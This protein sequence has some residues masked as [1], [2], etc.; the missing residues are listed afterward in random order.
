MGTV[1]R[2][3]GKQKPAAAPTTALAVAVLAALLAVIL[4][5][6]GCGPGPG[7]S[8]ALPPRGEVTLSGWTSSPAE[9]KLVK[10][11]VAS[12]QTLNPQI[13]V[14]YRPIRDYYLETLRADLA[15]G[16]AP[17]VF[18][19]SSQAAADFMA[20]G[21]LLEL[22][23][24]M[25]R[26]AVAPGDF[27]P[28]LVGAF[29]SQGAIY[30]IP[31]DFNTLGLFY[32]RSLFDRAGL[33]YPDLTWTW[34]DLERAAH[35]ISQAKIP[36]PAPPALRSTVPGLCLVPDPARWLPFA[37]QNGATIISPQGRCMLNSPPAR[38]AL[39]FY[40]G[41]KKSGAAAL[42]R[43]LGLK[44]AGQ[45]FVEGRTA[46]VIEG[47][48]LIPRIQQENPDLR[49]AVAQLPQGPKGR[50]NLIFTVGYAIPRTCPNPE[51]AW[52]LIKYLTGEGRQRAVL[53]TGFALPS[54]IALIDDSYYRQHPDSVALLRGVDYATLY[55]F[56]ALGSVFDYQLSSMLQSVLEK[57]EDPGTAL[58]RAVQEIDAG[59]MPPLASPVPP[60]IRP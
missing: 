19:V 52:L 42:P 48:W 1:R 34:K 49:Y 46:M 10:E 41:L 20:Q 22:G 50:A 36:L 40:V 29:K 58:A 37:L 39:E 44:D 47:G 54:R 28:N 32:N 3:T 53:E 45:A 17:D 25:Q 21:Q 57:G 23:P 2:R 14:K 60:E 15:K 4:L 31:K 16:T 7:P 5:G 26:D 11:A 30:A 13:K 38:Q 43:E 51:A 18:Y 35:A 59:H 55:R 9:E 8:A 6:T 24:Y 56:G 27:Y 12:F 33:P